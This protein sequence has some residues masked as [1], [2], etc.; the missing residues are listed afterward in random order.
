M[1]YNP[2]TEVIDEPIS[3][4]VRELSELKRLREFKNFANLPGT[5]TMEERARLTQV[6]NQLLDSLIEQVAEHPNKL[7]VLSQF[8]FALEIV[9]I[10][11]TEVREHFGDHLEKIMDILH[12]DSSDGLIN[13]YL[14]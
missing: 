12:I 1:D 4:S 6:F 14:C 11:D 8:K 13:F 7:W 9:Q 10:E 3:V 5:D 2:L